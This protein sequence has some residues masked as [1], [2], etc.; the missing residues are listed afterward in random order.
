MDFEALGIRI[1][2]GEERIDVAPLPSVFANVSAAEYTRLAPL[3][4]QAFI[5]EERRKML[6]L[7]P[8]R[9]RD[10]SE[11]TWNGYFYS[12]EPDGYV[13]GAHMDLSV[14]MTLAAEAEKGA[15]KES[16]LDAVKE[17][18]LRQM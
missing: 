12:S 6:Y 7:E 18:I 13:E 4:A 5:A 3:S 9:F 14:I 1:V 10:A 2:R 15:W 17:H 8:E 11:E 16:P